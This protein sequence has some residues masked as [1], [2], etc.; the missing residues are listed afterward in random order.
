MLQRCLI[1]AGLLFAFACDKHDDRPTPAQ[2]EAAAQ[3]SAAEKRAE[4]E[5][6]RADQAVEAAEDR[7]ERAEANLEKA[8][9][10]AEDHDD[11]DLGDDREARDED[12]RDGWVTFYRGKDRTADRGDYTLER[13]DDGSITTYRRTK[14]VSAPAERSDADIV[15]D[16]RARLAKNDTLRALKIDVGA[17]DRVVTLRGTVRS[18][19]DASHAVRLALGVPGV[20]KVVSHLSFDAVK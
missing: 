2:R 20:D 4:A 9:D 10:R 19:S 8:R 17:D 18:A 3:A 13:G 11:I 1:A 5:K 16:V 15:T 6:R 7:Q 14:P 12:A